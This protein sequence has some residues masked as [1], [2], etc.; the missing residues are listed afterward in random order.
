MACTH[1]FCRY[2]ADLGKWRRSASKMDKML[3]ANT[4]DISGSHSLLLDDRCGFFTQI[5]TNCSETLW[6]R[7]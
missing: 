3:E 4:P 5:L 6:P 7:T 1:A 2:A